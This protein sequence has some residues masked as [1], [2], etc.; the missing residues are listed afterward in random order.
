[1]TSLALLSAAGP[2][3]AEF[4]FSSKGTQPGGVNVD[5]FE[6]PGG[7]CKNCHRLGDADVT[8]SYTA[9]PTWAGTMM[10]NSVRDPLFLAALAVAEADVPAPAPGQVGIGQWC[11]RCHSPIAFL[12]DKTSPLDDTV[13]TSVE[14]QGVGCEVCHRSATDAAS[15]G[16]DP[17]APYLGNAQ[18]YFDDGNAMHGPYPD[19]D[20]QGHSGKLDPFTSTSELCGQ[21]HQVANPLVTLKD[22]AGVDT[23]K[24]F[25]L[26]TTYDEWK[27]SVYG[28]GGAEQKTCIDCHMP[29]RKGEHTVAGGPVVTNPPKR[30]DPAQH[31]FAGGNRWGIDAVAHADPAY[32]AA[33]REAF[34]LARGAAEAMLR[35]S[36]SLEPLAAPAGE[37][38]AGAAVAFGVRVR[39][40]SG[41]KFPTGYADGRRAFLQIGFV[42][43]T[44]REIVVSGRYEDDDLVTANDP[45][46]HVYEAQH[47]RRGGEA[48]D[49]GH[50]AK[51]DSIV[52]DSRI[53]P[54]GFVGSAVT[55]PVGVPWFDDPGGGYRDYDEVSYA[56][57]LPSAFT[58]GPGQ[59]FIR[60]V[61][62]PTTKHYV[63]FLEQANAGKNQRGRALREAWEATGKAAPFVVAQLTSS[64]TLVGG[65][66]PPPGTGGVAGSAA[67]AG[68]SVAP[69]G[70]GG[71]GGVGL[72]G[73]GGEAGAGLPNPSTPGL[74]V[75]GGGGCAFGPTD[76]DAR[77][78]LVA[79]GLVALALGASRRRRW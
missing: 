40:L 44:G 69:G 62:Q 13:W 78:A 55:R 24:P 27:D 6:S 38:R 9:Y 7:D 60:L 1:M 39:N 19:F 45:Q 29:R 21:C 56:S 2:A 79:A 54:P 77:G 35:A 61:Y 14:R 15:T 11:V 43:R 64:V 51:Y 32:A 74:R 22:A 4:L 10:A 25:P 50:L 48:T 63:E 67:G 72:G 28:R 42:D 36:A 26:D 59:A 3:S 49:E 23:G 68:G 34:D 47:A 33:N 52:K 31:L 30:T 76:H 20:A 18:I 66:L 57:T 73:A 8:P 37:L 5:V 16:N 41:H 17:G 65:V 46:L 58:D 71:T 70:A 12:K 75:E 53:P